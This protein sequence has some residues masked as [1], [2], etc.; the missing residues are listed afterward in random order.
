MGKISLD[1]L[2]ITHRSESEA[3]EEPIHFK[4]DE[5]SDSS[6]L[7]LHARDKQIII[8]DF[9]IG[10]IKIVHPEPFTLGTECFRKVVHFLQH[11]FVSLPMFT[12][13]VE[14]GVDSFD[15][16]GNET[17]DI[18]KRTSKVRIENCLY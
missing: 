8:A 1:L 16:A 13:T 15:Q 4:G 10:A 3:M 9:N 14:S 11:S 17:S 18:H 2:I 12:G 7:I 5:K 6:R